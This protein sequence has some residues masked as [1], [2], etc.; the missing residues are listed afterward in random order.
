MWFYLTI[1]WFILVKDMA[2]HWSELMNF[3]VIK[4]DELKIALQEKMST[5]IQGISTYISK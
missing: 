2:E 5:K 3:F 1:I 4:L